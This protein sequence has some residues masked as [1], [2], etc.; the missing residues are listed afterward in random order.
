M[1]ILFLIWYCFM[2]LGGNMEYL[3]IAIGIIMVVLAVYY[4]YLLVSGD[5]SR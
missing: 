3:T 4:I 2:G 5:E 1:L